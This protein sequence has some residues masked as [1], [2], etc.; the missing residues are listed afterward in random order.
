MSPPTLP[1]PPTTTRRIARSMAVMLAV[2]VASF[3]TNAGLTVLLHEVLGVPTEL[4]FLAGMA[5][6]MAINFVAGR[7]IFEARDGDARTQLA[8]FVASAIGFRAAEYVAFLVIHTWLGADYRL[9]VC[10][11]LLVSFLAK[12]FFFRAVVFARGWRWS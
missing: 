12:F 1:P 5:T 6:V 4:A 10:G 8:R 11:V 2:G 3:A 7:R 9:A